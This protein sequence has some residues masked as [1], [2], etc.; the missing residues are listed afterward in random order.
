MI[1][2]WAQAPAKP[3]T[4]SN[5]IALVA[6]GALT[7]N[8]VNEVRL[9]GLLFQPD[10]QYRLQ[11]KTAGADL[12][13]LAAL[14]AAKI[15]ASAKSDG[16][17]QRVDLVRRLA[18]A[19]DLIKKKQYPDAVRELNAALAVDPEDA[20]AGCVMGELLRQQEQWPAAVSV[21][22]EVVN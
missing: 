10:N 8:I 19:A 16:D 9:R 15:N 20:A 6:G 4:D 17:K 14:N 3:L 18:R 13:L 11:L 12:A 1:S 2:A 21:Y 22:R 5:L 7:E